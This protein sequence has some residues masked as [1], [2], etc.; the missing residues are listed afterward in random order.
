MLHN[1]LLKEH[2]IV[3]EQRKEID[4][5]Q[6]GVKRATGVH[7][8]G[9][10]QRGTEQPCT[11]GGQQSLKAAPRPRQQHFTISRHASPRGGFLFA[12]LTAL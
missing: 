9:E 4:C 2:R 12:S 3:K 11:A 8:K 10:R 7:P 1:E 5:A 6:S